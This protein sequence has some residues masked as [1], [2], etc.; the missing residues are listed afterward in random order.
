MDSSFSASRIDVGGFAL[1]NDPSSAA[2][3][4]TESAS[5]HRAMRFQGPS[6]LM[7]S[8]KG[9]GWSLTVGC[10]MS[11][12]FPPPGDFIWRSASSVISSSVAIGVEIRSSSLLLSSALRKSRKEPNAMR[13]SVNRTVSA[14]NVSN[15]G[16]R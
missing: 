6:V 5:R 10:S 14:R 4:S 15:G 1:I 9:D 16:R 13:R 12:A 3:S 8:G 7:A 11:N 2:A